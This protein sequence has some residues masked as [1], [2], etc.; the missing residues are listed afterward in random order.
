MANKDTNS[1]LKKLLDEHDTTIG[2]NNY[3]HLAKW[4]Y[5]LCCKVMDD[6][7]DSDNMILILDGM[8]ARPASGSNAEIIKSWEIKDRKVRRIL[9][10]RV[11]ETLYHITTHAGVATAHEM[12]KAICHAILAI[13]SGEDLDNLLTGWTF[14][15]EDYL[16]IK[17]DEIGF[18]NAAARMAGSPE[19]DEKAQIGDLVKGLENG[20]WL[21][22]KSTWDPVP[23]EKSL[24]S[25]LEEVRLEARLCMQGLT[26]SD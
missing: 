23:P 16:L 22:F 21:M 1:Y 20:I 26:N 17:Q 5:K 18:Y 24:A 13:V 11:D 25:F 9:L 3:N 15:L 19:L 12:Y 2:L 7:V 14:K 6:E 4:D 8:M 10:G